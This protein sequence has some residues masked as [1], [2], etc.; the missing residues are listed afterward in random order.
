MLQSSSKNASR[1]RKSINELLL[2]FS[3]LLSPQLAPTII[4]TLLPVPSKTL[5]KSLPP[6]RK[7]LVFVWTALCLIPNIL[8]FDTLYQSLLLIS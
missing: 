6:P 5:V 7:I 3:A 4:T 2:I 8:K 1:F